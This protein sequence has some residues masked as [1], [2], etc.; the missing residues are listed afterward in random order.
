MCAVCFSARPAAAAPYCTLHTHTIVADY[1]M[2]SRVQAVAKKWILGALCGGRAAGCSAFA[3]TI[4]NIRD[5][6]SLLYYST[7]RVILSLIL[8]HFAYT[9]M[10]QCLM[11]HAGKNMLPLQ[12][13]GSVRLLMQ[14]AR[15]NLA[16]CEQRD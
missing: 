7:A 12:A 14:Y 13:E 11:P 10:I 3:L 6:L 2:Q 15:Q 9:N 16:E 5:S 8:H 4:A 1:I